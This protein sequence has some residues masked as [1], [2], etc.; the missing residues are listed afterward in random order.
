MVSW[1]GF[2]LQ[3][4]GQ[5]PQYV[6]ASIQ[7]RRSFKEEFVSE[8]LTRA[9][10]SRPFSGNA[11]FKTLVIGTPDQWGAAIHG[12][13]ATGKAL[14]STKQAEVP[15]RRS[16]SAV[17]AMCDGACGQA[18]ALASQR[19][20]AAAN[21]QDCRSHVYVQ[22]PLPAHSRAICFGGPTLPPSRTW[23]GQ[24]VKGHQYLGATLL[25]RA[26]ANVHK[27]LH[28]PLLE[29]EAMEVACCEGLTAGMC[30]ESDTTERAH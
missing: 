22:E 21:C 19:W 25:H 7:G 13:A 30:I 1:L 8:V 12:A 29:V 11:V 3:S 15:A 17:V 23:A 10:V 20:P 6:A 26:Q 2:S 5:G 24:D 14:A 4:R 27:P 16:M 28:R 9:T 18:A